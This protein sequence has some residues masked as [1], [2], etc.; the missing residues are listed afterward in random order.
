MSVGRPLLRNRGHCAEVPMSLCELG[1]KEIG[2][3][4]R[5]RTMALCPF[6]EVDR[7]RWVFVRMSLRWLDVG[8]HRGR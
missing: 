8:H 1:N 5:G 3:L 2:V 7:G 4:G 6:W